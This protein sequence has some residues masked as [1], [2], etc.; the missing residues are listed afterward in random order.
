MPKVPK[1]QLRKKKNRIFISLLGLC[2][3]IQLHGQ[4]IIL[5]SLA[6]GTEMR[7]IRYYVPQELSPS[8]PILLMTDAQNLFDQKTSYAGEWKIDEFMDSLPPAHRALIIAIDH[9]NTNRINELTHYSH[10]DYGGGNAGAFEDFILDKVLPHSAERFK[11]EF[12]NRPMAVAGSSLGG[13]FALQLFLDHPEHFQACAAMSPSL[14]YHDAYL[15]NLEAAIFP[16]P[17]FLFLS[18]GRAE[19]ENHVPNLQEL[20]GIAF[21]KAKLKTTLSIND[22]G[23]NEA[24]WTSTFR[25]FY[26]LFLQSL[27]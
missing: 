23:H 25:E 1:Q 22:H 13:I 10:K 11:L 5:D 15:E 16:K 2:F 14:W 19:S 12:K 24:Q 6:F 27:R 26:V 9:G 21:A 4:N 17:K 3:A 7:S 18:G 8:T 20:A